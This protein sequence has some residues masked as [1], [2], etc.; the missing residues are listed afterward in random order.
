MLDKII[1]DTK[2]KLEELIRLEEQKYREIEN[3][4][5]AQK[6]I[7]GNLKAEVIETN[8]RRSRSEEDYNRK[9]AEVQ[10]LKE[11]LQDEL[12]SRVK[13]MDEVKN[14]ER[15]IKLSLDNAKFFTESKHE[16]LK[17]QEN[18][19]GQLNL[20]KTKLE[21]LIYETSE[22]S[23][24]FDVKIKDVLALESANNIKADKLSRLEQVLNDRESELNGRQEELKRIEKMLRK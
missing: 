17:K 24:N 20:D 2:K 5:K 3:S 8:M 7:E 18:I 23:K 10:K 13:I 11:E 6:A 16:E 1:E 12:A 21:K 22:K 4:L 9:L 19:T 14:N 15:L